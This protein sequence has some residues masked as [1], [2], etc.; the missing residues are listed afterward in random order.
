MRSHLGRWV[1]WSDLC[2]QSTSWLPCWEWIAACRVE[3]RDQL[4]FCNSIVIG[5]RCWWPSKRDSNWSRSDS[6][7]DLF[8]RQKW[9]DFMMD[10]TQSGTE[11]WIEGVLAWTAGRMKLPKIEIKKPYEERVLGGKDWEFCFGYRK[12]DT[13]IRLPKGDTE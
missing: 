4:V 9:D 11:R 5:E 7:L 2:S 3:T 1:T 6:I 13:A 10:E 8:W 12:F